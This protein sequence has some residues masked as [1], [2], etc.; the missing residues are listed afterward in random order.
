MIQPLLLF[1]VG[2]FA[3]SLLSVLPPNWLL[4]TASIIAVFA[5]YKRSFS[6]L[7]L[8]AGI[9]WGTVSG[10][11]LMRHQLPLSLD[12]ETFLV[13]G[14]IVGLPQ[15]NHRRTR[16][17]LKLDNSRLLYGHND[18]QPSLDKLLLSWYGT[19]QQI[20]PGQRWR[21]T[22]K[23][24]CPRGFSNPGG[25]NYRH[26]LL[27]QGFSATGYVRQSAENQLLGTNAQWLSH[28]RHVLRQGIEQQP[29]NERQKGLLRALVIGDS[30]G[31]GKVD[32]QLFQRTGT[33]HLLVISG[34][35]VG[36]F[37]L[38][39][40]GLVNL[41]CR[42]LTLLWPAFPV[43][44]W[45][46]LASLVGAG[47]YAALS[48]FGLPATRALAMVAT[49]AVVR[50]LRSYQSSF[51]YLAAALAAVAIIDPLAIHSSGF[52]L[53]FGAVFGLLW[54][55]APLRGKVRGWQGHWQK[56][57]RPQWTVFVV[58]AGLL[59]PLFGQLSVTSI[60]INCLAIPWLSLLI[61]P[62]CLFGVIASSAIPELSSWC[63]QLAGWQLQWFYQGL[64]WADGGSVVAI[65]AMALSPAMVILLLASGLLMLLPRGV[66][67][68]WLG[69]L[70]FIVVFIATPQR[71]TLS[72]TV[73]DVGQGLAVVVTTKNHT[74][75]YDVGA[76]FSERFDAG[77]AVVAPFLR[78][79]GIRRVDR[80]MVSHGDNDHAGGVSGLLASIPVGDIY[81]G[82]LLGTSVDVTPC[83]GGQSW[84]WD[85]VQF[86]V[87]S[88]L[89]FDGS[90]N[91]AS[92]V[93]LITHGTNR[94]LLPGDIESTQ[95]A[96][97]HSRLGPVDLVVAPH[98][99]SATSSSYPFVNALKPEHVIYSAGYRHHFGHPHPNVVMNYQ[100]VG[101]QQ[102]S[103]AESGAVS[104]TLQQGK[105]MLVGERQG[106]RYFWQ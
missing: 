102:W 17:Q 36:L 42:P 46:T 68:R 105:W 65:P 64:Q 18:W 72:A 69:L 77:S 44:L 11:Q 1:A 20:E 13:E 81:S 4:A 24:R 33:T 25:F 32:W 39:C 99:G 27:Q 94:L 41:L 79:R 61:V 95:E 78:S 87:L 5:A 31:L 55:F 56:F 86:Q 71:P 58:L 52:W 74:L 49:V 43:Q 82:E 93:L 85:N 23:L 9:F 62:L 92:C 67:G 34:L 66:S 53:S 21:L 90:G 30:S 98:H 59:L 28:T 75:V 73:L 48:G 89:A 29:L 63:W 100:R 91:N 54:V 22:V 103:T 37:A 7:F 60:V 2:V 16:F 104:A 19:E 51:G 6:F 12:T 106:Y 96:K 14:V 38:L 76:A 88:P 15:T 70:P 50:L 35:H 26:W 84:Q 8:V 101:S 57:G 47:F 97:I 80:L 10:H 40:Y 45:A 3:V 83:R